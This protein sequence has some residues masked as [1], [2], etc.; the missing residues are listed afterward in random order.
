MRQH[1]PARPTA[2][3]F[4]MT[5]FRTASLI[6]GLA[7]CVASPVFSREYSAAPPQKNAPPLAQRFAG[8]DAAKYKTPAWKG[9]IAADIANKKHSMRTR[10]RNA[11]KYACENTDGVNFAGQYILFSYGCGTSCIGFDVIDAA[12]GKIYDGMGIS[13]YGYEDGW[14]DLDLKYE[15]SSTLLYVQGGIEQGNGS[16][17]FEFKDGKFRLLQHSPVVGVEE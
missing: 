10:A 12:S 13:G 3:I 8:I 11:L 4:P 1:H 9:K 5:F 7:V 2:R 14:V 6:V 15:K 16:F 17:A